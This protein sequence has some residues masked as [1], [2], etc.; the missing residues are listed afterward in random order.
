MDSG[1]GHHNHSTTSKTL[2]S[3]CFWDD[4]DVTFPRVRNRFCVV[5]KWTPSRSE[6]GL[7]PVFCLG[8]VKFYP[9]N[10]IKWHTLSL[11]GST[12]LRVMQ[13]VSDTPLRIETQA[14]L[15]IQCTQVGMQEYNDYKCTLAKTCIVCIDKPKNLT[16]WTPTYCKT[17]SYTLLH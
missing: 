5:L 8:S 3:G 6:S 9:E 10:L 7:C 4:T 12:I 16:G 17:N 13:R 14:Q 1:C 15:H 2:R 11:Q